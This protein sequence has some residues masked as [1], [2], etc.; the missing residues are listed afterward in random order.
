M[1]FGSRA[2]NLFMPGNR[3]VDVAILRRNVEITHHQQARIIAQL[4]LKMARDL[5]QPIQFVGELFA[6]HGLA[7]DHIEIGDAHAS[8]GRNQNAA[9]RVIQA[10]NVCHHI[11]NRLPG[12]QGHTVVGLLPAEGD[13]IAHRL[14]RRTRKLCIFQLGFLN[15]EHI[16][17]RQRT[18]LLHMRQPHIERVHIPAGEFHAPSL[19]YRRR[20]ASDVRVMRIQ[21]AGLPP[22]V[23][24]G[25]WTRVDAHATLFAPAR[26]P[27]RSLS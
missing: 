25:L 1:A 15:A 6:A 17:L 27:W 3:I 9:L 12:Q 23:T 26:D 10:C 22:G 11:M 2:K 8:D 21:V 18:P 14:D 19:A 7:V 4:A 24:N 16:R 20:R 5:V 13:L